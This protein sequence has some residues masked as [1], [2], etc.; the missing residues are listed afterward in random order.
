[1]VHDFRRNKLIPG[2]QFLAVEPEYVTWTGESE[3]YPFIFDS[4]GDWAVTTSVAPPEGFV[5][6][7]DSL[8]AQVTTESEAVQF[9][10][11]D[12]GSDWV[13]TE[14]LHRL[15]HGARRETVRTRVGVKVAPDLA[16]EKGIDV[17]GRPLDSAG[18]P[19]PTAG[20]D[21]RAPNEVE[22]TGWIEPSARD[23]EWTIKVRA[24]VDA[25]ARVALMR[26][27]L[28][29]RILV[30]GALEAG[31]YEPT[32]D[33]RDSQRSRLIPGRY[34]IVVKVGGSVVDSV[35]LAIDLVEDPDSCTGPVAPPPG[36]RRRVGEAP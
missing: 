5:S 30:D 17:D 29:E 6:D 26:G 35:W 19:V 13:P 34:R 36:Q 21:P 1:M 3:M 16:R 8:S 7:Y 22:V 27:T 20:H 2:S 12:V 9:T 4:V 25:D 18:R 31:D 10:I 24:N 33:G 11:T 32:W 23:A 15:T 14:V 28:T